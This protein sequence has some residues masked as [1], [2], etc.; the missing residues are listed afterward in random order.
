MEPHLDT[1]CFAKHF[2]AEC[3]EEVYRGAM[4]VAALRNLISLV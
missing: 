1:F 2:Y 3:F 4:S